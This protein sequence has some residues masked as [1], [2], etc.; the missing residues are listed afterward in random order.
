MSCNANQA[1]ISGC[2]DG[3]RTS[4]LAFFKL[5]VR[6]C[7]TSRPRKV[8]CTTFCSKVYVA[9][10][11]LEGLHGMGGM[12]QTLGRLAEDGAAV[13]TMTIIEEQAPGADAPV[14]IFCLAIIR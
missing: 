11:F 3:K 9:A 7:I 2:F 13:H 12:L 4:R 10:T 8:T 6:A 1:A 5:P 14:S